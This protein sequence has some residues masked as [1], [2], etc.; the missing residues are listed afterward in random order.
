MGV[1][2]I[3]RLL[4]RFLLLL[5][6]SVASAAGPLVRAARA[7]VVDLMVASLVESGGMGGSFGFLVPSFASYVLTGKMAGSPS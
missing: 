7:A 2:G 6:T 4:V 1:V 5:L 3:G